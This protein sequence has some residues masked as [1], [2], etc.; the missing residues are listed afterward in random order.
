M[1]ITASFLEKHRACWT[2]M[3]RFRAQFPK[4]V[5]LKPDIWEKL[6]APLVIHSTDVTWV[7]ARVLSPEDFM[8]YDRAAN[9]PWVEKVL[10]KIMRR[11]WSE[12]TDRRA[13]INLA[14]LGSFFE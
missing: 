5:T 7:A 3:D 13:R 14:V 6:P 2:G 4:G 10:D 12:Y 9:A 8:I 1:R 11:N